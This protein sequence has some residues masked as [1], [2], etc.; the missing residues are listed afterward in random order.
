MIEGP[1]GETYDITSED[2]I[3]GLYDSLAK[4][5]ADER[6]AWYADINKVISRLSKLGYKIKKKT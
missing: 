2:E 3:R 6:V 4:N 1:D 5:E